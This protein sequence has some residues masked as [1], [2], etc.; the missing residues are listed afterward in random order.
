MWYNVQMHVR[1]NRVHLSYIK[2]SACRGNV[3]YALKLSVPR[4][5]YFLVTYPLIV[6]IL[7]AIIGRRAN[8]YRSTR[9]DP[10]EV[11]CA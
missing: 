8:I 10:E 5:N 4:D 6:I 7:I 1:A 9:I 3:F 2:T 11:D